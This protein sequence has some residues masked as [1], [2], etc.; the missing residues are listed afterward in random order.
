MS[1]KTMSELSD[2]PL[3]V[4][5]MQYRHAVLHIWSDQ[6]L[7]VC[8]LVMPV[9]QSGT[10]LV[11]LVCNLCYSTARIYVERV[12]VMIDRCN[13]CNQCT[14]PDPCMTLST[15][16]VGMMKLWLLARGITHLW[17]KELARTHPSAHQVSTTTLL[18][19]Q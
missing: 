9:L 7:L 19:V 15:V 18:C 12:N 8:M 13:I 3:C 10:G 14:S 1:Q 17:R 5:I 11:V 4:L 6:T 2:P 16:N